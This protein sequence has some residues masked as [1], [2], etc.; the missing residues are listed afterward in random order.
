MEL[1]FK[2]ITSININKVLPFFACL[3]LNY[4]LNNL[5]LIDMEELIK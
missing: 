5:I 3:V 2:N 4:I 1:S